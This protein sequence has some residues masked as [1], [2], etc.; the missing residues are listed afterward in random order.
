MSEKQPT[1]FVLCEFTSGDQFD[2]RWGRP[3]I[4]NGHFRAVG[5]VPRPN[6]NGPDHNFIEN[7]GDQPAMHRFQEPAVFASKPESGLNHLLVCGKIELQSGG[8]VESADKAVAGVRERLHSAGGES[9]DIPFGKPAHSGVGR[10]KFSVWKRPS[11]LPY[12]SPLLRRRWMAESFS[13]LV[14]SCPFFWSL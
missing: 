14:K 1:A 7:G 13:V 11:G 10:R 2:I 6:A 12:H 5:E 4:A 8:V 9:T 3:L